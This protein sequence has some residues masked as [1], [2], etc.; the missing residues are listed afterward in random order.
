MSP[1]TETDEPED[2]AMAE[3]QTETTAED[4]AVGAAD[5]EVAPG[6]LRVVA[7]SS[8]YVT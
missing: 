7:P 6:A 8:R 3:T 1:L 5:V 2:T 4:D